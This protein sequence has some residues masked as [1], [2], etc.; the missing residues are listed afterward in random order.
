MDEIKTKLEAYER[1]VKAW[2]ESQGSEQR[3]YTRLRAMHLRAE[4][5]ETIELQFRIIER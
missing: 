5:L 1:A 4:L 2:F 3:E